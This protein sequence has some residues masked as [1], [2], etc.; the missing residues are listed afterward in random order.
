MESQLSSL[1]SLIET[2]AAEAVRLTSEIGGHEGDLE[3]WRSVFFF[4]FARLDVFKNMVVAQRA[5][6]SSNKAYCLKTKSRK[7]LVPK[8]LKFDP[9]PYKAG[10][11]LQVYQ[12]RHPAK[13][14]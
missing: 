6:N 8:G 1:S 2:S 7:I 11:F 3:T 14:P 4:F 10:G 9:R 12:P 5:P 13:T